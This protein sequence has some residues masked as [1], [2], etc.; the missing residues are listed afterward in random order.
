MTETTATQN[1]EATTPQDLT[2]DIERIVE[3]IGQVL[4]G[5][6]T[7]AA[8]SALLCVVSGATTNSDMFDPAQKKAAAL[9]F[10]SAAVQASIEAGVTDTEITSAMVQPGFYGERAAE[11]PAPQ[12]IL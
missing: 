9:F 12:I 11:M 5:E 3:K 6:P 2:N 1:P 8:F 4:H 7:F 10:L